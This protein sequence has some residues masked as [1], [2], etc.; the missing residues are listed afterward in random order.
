MNPI[1]PQIGQN[2]HDK[3]I[4]GICTQ[5]TLYSLSVLFFGLFNLHNVHITECTYFTGLTKTSSQMYKIQEHKDSLD[6]S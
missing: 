4:D 3:K 6:L 1:Q 2:W 5:R